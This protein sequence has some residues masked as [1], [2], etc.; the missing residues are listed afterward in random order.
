MAGLTDGISDGK[1]YNQVYLTSAE[2]FSGNLDVN[3]NDGNIAVF[4][5]NFIAVFV[6]NLKRSVSKKALKAFQIRTFGSTTT[7]VPI[8]GPPR[9]IITD[10][11]TVHFAQCILLADRA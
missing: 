10:S 1:D 9:L 11:H 2:N 7:L 3:H 5:V 4:I 8:R 6:I